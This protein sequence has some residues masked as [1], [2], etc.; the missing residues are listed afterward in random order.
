MVTTQEALNSPSALLDEEEQ[1]LAQ[2]LLL[3]AAE[4]T[5]SCGAAFTTETEPSVEMAEDLKEPGNDDGGDSGGGTEI[6]TS[7]AVQQQEQQQELP[8]RGATHGVGEEDSSIR[9]P[10][11]PPLS[12]LEAVASGSECRPVEN[13][14]LSVPL[15]SSPTSGHSHS[16][17]EIQQENIKHAL[18]EIISEIDR[19]ME[20]DLS[21]EEVSLLAAASRM[22]AG[23]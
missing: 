20:A 23:K 2:E 17:R 11:P 4:E 5:F 1:L 12:T 14:D 13:S 16:N 10:Q 6:N 9:E 22:A 18:H 7:G 8:E 3:E 15:S 21:N 19:E